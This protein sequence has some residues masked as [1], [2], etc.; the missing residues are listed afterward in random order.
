[1]LGCNRPSFCKVARHPSLE[2][3]AAMNQSGRISPY[4]LQQIRSIRTRRRSGWVAALGG[5]LAALTVVAA[6]PVGVAQGVGMP[7]TAIDHATGGA[8]TTRAALQQV[9]V[10]SGGCFWGVQAV[11]EHVRGVIGVTAGYAG[12]EART[13]AYEEVSSGTT[14]HAESV[15]IVF[16][17]AR[18]SYADLLK[19]FF[20]V[21]HD[22]T[23]LN[24]QGPDEGTQY[25]SAVWY[26][27]D[28]QKRVAESVIRQ[29]SSS[30]AFSRPIVTQV[31]P[32]R[33][34]YSAEGYHQ[35]YFVHHPDAPY[36]VINDKPK[37]ENLQ[38]AL[39]T[40]YQDTPVLYVAATATP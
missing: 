29:L 8:P 15:R 9:A 37:V 16:D 19:V 12:G 30:H 17:P 2:A 28:D 22:P 20:T 33:G 24:R 35:D 31:A 13:A 27:S 25:R 11:F 34:F 39:P 23:L 38:H 14:G 21:A 6:R 7:A 40:L 3:Y 5:I 32:L 4:P 1:M 36:I 18:V 10:F 26:T